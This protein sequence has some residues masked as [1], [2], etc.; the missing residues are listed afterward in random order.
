MR[1]LA[2][3]KSCRDFKQPEFD[4]TGLPKSSLDG[5]RPTVLDAPK[6]GE[7]RD[8][9]RAR[10]P[11]KLRLLRGEQLDVVGVTKRLGTNQREGNARY[12][13]VARVAAD[14][15]LRGAKDR[16]GF[17][18]LGKA[19]AAVP[20]LNKVAE[21]SYDYF[22]YE[23]TVIFQD[24]HADLIDELGEEVKE[25][26]KRVARAVERLG[27][28]PNPYLAILVADGD[29]MGA[30]ISSLD[31]VVKHQTF[32]QALAGF[33][34][35]AK[36]IVN[37]DHNGVLIY[38]GGDDVLAFLPADK[39]LACARELHD[40]FGELLANFSNE[41]G[42]PPTLSVG[43]AI[44]HFMENLEDLLEYGRAAEK[45][46]KEPDRDGL[47]VRLYKRGGAPIKVRVRWTENPV[48]RIT[49]YAELILAEAVPGKL[50]YDLRN[51][52]R[53]Y[54]GWRTETSP[55]M[56]S[57]TKAIRQDVVRVI[58]DKQPR[59]GRKYMPEVE[60][61]IK[62]R[63]RDATSVQQFAEEL[64]IARQMATTLRQA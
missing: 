13:S 42:N 40:N 63:L 8:T 53:H 38:A 52:A 10:W 9:Y 3:R 51:L 60:E 18:E 56:E 61:A 11:K 19:C 29:K 22:P 39:C 45:H 25:P 16:E 31:S 34:G 24:R 30:A 27:G 54:A 55:E 48:E 62:E 14:T 5:Q 20:G 44:G 43:L 35:S 2:G 23:G 57:A 12:P 64:L 32:S 47:A 1:L 7:S 15:W 17:T 28:E 58:R 6:S 4:D 26:L 50:P 41:K 37:E 46:A 36:K 49:R 21:P 59:S 33:A